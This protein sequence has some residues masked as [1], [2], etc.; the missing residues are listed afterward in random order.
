[1]NK[2]VLFSIITLVAALGLASSGAVAGLIATNE[3]VPVP[4]AMITGSGTEADIA[5]YVLNDGYVL[6]V[7]GTESAV[8]EFKITDDWN[9][10]TISDNAQL[11]MVWGRV[12]LGLNNS[13]SSHNQVVVTGTGSILINPSGGSGTF[14]IGDNTGYGYHNLTVK[15]GG[16]VTLVSGRL[17]VGARVG[18]TNNSLVVTGMNSVVT[19]HQFNVG[20]NS[21][22]NGTADIMDKSLLKIT[23]ERDTMVSMVGTT[24][25][26]RLGGGF[27][28]W[29]TDKTASTSI[30]D[31]KV[32]V[33]QD[34]GLTW[35]DGTR[36][37]AGAGYWTSTYYA[38]DAEALA[39]TGYEGLGGYTIIT[40]G[41]PEPTTMALL[42]IGGI[43]VLVRRRRK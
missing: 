22:V 29:I 13:T 5:D 25:F 14:R 3:E 30:T 1:M 9:R 32:K 24:N 7:V 33:T 4:P 6:S 2:R 8:K 41:V 26:L 12:V 40:G 27:V 20:Y 11:S 34:G 42:A 28:A 39:A 16:K 10:L 31:A 19:T 37:V 21:A 35:V 36:D 15:N 18:S 23:D 43:G 17:A 38:T